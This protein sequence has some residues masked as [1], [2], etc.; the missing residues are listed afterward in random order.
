M[1]DSVGRC[2]DASGRRAVRYVWFPWMQQWRILLSPVVPR[3]QAARPVRSLSRQHS[4]RPHRPLRRGGGY[5]ALCVITL[6]SADETRPL[7]AAAGAHHAFRRGTSY[8]SCALSPRAICSAQNSFFQRLAH[9][10]PRQPP[11]PKPHPPPRLPPST[12]PPSSPPLF[13]VPEIVVGRCEGRCVAASGER[14]GG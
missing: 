8:C 4:A 2:A 1:C 11:L 6:P 9:T 3:R 13:F 12:H 5:R 7:P 14:R 10:L